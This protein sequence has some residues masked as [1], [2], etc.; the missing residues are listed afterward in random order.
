MTR[1]ELIYLIPYF[2]SLLLSLMLLLFVWSKRSA[3]GALAL[4]FYILGQSIWIAAFMLELAGKT[5]EMKIFWDGIEWLGANVILVAIPVFAVQYTDYKIRHMRRWFAASLIL[6]FVFTILTF[7]NPLHG[8]I[9]QNIEMLPA[10]PFRELRYDITPAIYGYAIYGYMVLFWGVY[11]IARRLIRPQGLYRGQ[12]ITIVTGL[13]IPV[14]GTAFTLAGLQ[15]TPERDTLPLTAALGNLV[16]AWGF[17]RF[18]ILEIAPVGRD[19]VFEALADPVVILDK[20]NRVIDVNA[21]MLDLLGKK[22]GEV[23]GEPAKKV[24]DD[25][26]IPIK[27]YMQVSH[28][29]TETSFK[30]NNREIYYEL[31]VWPLFGFGKE[32]TGRVY[33]SHDI[34]ALKEL[35]SELRRLNTQLEDRVQ[36]RTRELAEAYESTLEGL[37]RALELRDK[38]TEGHSR[39]VTETTLKIAQKIGIAGEALEDIRSGAIL[40]DIGKISIPDE[41]LHK[42]GKLTPEERAIINQHP[43]TAFKLL[44]RIPFLTKAIEIPYCH[45]EKWDGS[46]YPRGL[47]GEEIPLSARIFAIADVWDALSNDRPYNKAWTRDRILAYFT[48][49]TGRHFDPLIVKT[50]LS[51]VEQGEI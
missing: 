12:L 10:D 51:M 19:R 38:E 2:T 21:A 22:D 35:E 11:I 43:E 20:H 5:L 17:F 1:S 49:E 24:F 3:R 13:L 15:I 9:Y 41:I 28:A 23:I 31:T 7:T 32:M 47:K 25:F 46:G 42:K 4:F 29:R 14:I 6:P 36:A 33:I 34:T 40:H 8:L 50:F 39:R 45:H 44:S 48:E 27:M 30:L 26:P 16:T 18:R 37:A